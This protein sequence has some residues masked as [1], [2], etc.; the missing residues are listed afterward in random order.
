MPMATASVVLEGIVGSTAYGL[1]TAH[2]DVDKLGIKLLPSKDFLGLETLTESFQSQVTTNPDVTYH[3]LGKFCRL[4]LACNPTI[5]ELLWLPDE[6]YTEKSTIGQ[7]LIQRRNSFLSANKVKDSFMGYAK[8]Q[9]HRLSERGDSFS[10]ET[11]NRTQKHARHLLRLMYQGYTLY[12]TGILP[13]R[14]DNPEVYHQ[15]GQDVAKNTDLARDYVEYY[16]ALF[17]GSSSVLPDQPDRSSI[18]DF[19]RDTRM[20]AISYV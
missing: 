6:L 16:E 11:K 9:F 2:S 17:R 14:L 1:A 4:A 19:V 8:S 10:S 3:D 13:I 7:D 15:F 18:E 12:N 20:G 5:I